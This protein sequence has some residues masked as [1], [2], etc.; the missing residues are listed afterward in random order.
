MTICKC[1]VV[2]KA[3]YV[4][5]KPESN[6]KVT[7]AK[8]LEVPLV[9]QGNC[10]FPGLLPINLVEFSSIAWFSTHFFSSIHFLRV[11]EAISPNVFDIPLHGCMFAS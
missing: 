8:D 11:R 4:F 7:I 5:L 6:F 9:F 1:H 2:P 10:P 3:K